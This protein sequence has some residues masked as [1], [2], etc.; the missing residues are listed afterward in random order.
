MAAWMPRIF[1]IP[2]PELDPYWTIEQVSNQ[3]QHKCVEDASIKGRTIE[4]L[5][6]LSDAL[7]DWALA[8]TAARAEVKSKA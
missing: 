7:R 5:V 6:T 2:S 1:A 3:L 8:L 4:S